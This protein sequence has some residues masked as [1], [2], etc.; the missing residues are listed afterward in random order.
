MGEPG[1]NGQVWA[2]MR[3][4]R[5]I[6]DGH[7]DGSLE[8]E[9]SKILGLVEVSE[10]GILEGGEWWEDGPGASSTPDLREGVG[11]VPKARIGWRLRP[12]LLLPRTPKRF[13]QGT[14]CLQY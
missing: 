11:G 1:E 7:L 2:D 8:A 10:S 3:P 14:H 12:S 4:G 5:E 6:G 9:G 13:P